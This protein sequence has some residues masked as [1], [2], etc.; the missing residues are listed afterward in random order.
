MSRA[1]IFAVVGL[2]WAPE[3]HAACHHYSV[4]HYRWP[5]HCEAR[6][7]VVAARQLRQAPALSLTRAVAVVAPSAPVAAPLDEEALRAHAIEALKRQFAG[8][9]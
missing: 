6:L 9:N 2:L 1:P 7:A 4:W 5:Q 3:G 8:E